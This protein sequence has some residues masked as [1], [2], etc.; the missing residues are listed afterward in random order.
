ML[1]SIVLVVVVAPTF[2]TPRIAMHMCLRMRMRA[3]QA[4]LS[5]GASHTSLWNCTY[6]PRCGSQEGPQPGRI[7]GALAACHVSAS[8]L[9]M[10]MFFPGP[11][12]PG[13]GGEG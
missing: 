9:G 7:V 3:P 8:L 10:R 5:V 11:A 2:I 1:P 4:S 12:R 13:Q 6:L